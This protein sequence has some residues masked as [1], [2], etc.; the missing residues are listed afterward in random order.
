[1]EDVYIGTFVGGHPALD[2]VNSISDSNKSREKSRIGDWDQFKLWARAANIFPE[3][4]LKQLDTVTRPSNHSSILDGVHQLREVTYRMLSS[5]ASGETPSKEHQAFVEAQIKTAISNGVLGHRDRLHQWTI[6]IDHPDWVIGTLALSI[7]S[8]IRSQ[9][10]RKLREC[11]RCSWF[12]LD[13]GR[14]RGR[15]WCDM[16]KCGNRSK[17]QSFRD[18]QKS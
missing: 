15:K 6:A 16:R 17:S 10:F 14:G 8:L 9:D 11:G 4:Y 18:R 2:F 1:M 5:I 12:F 3:E 13:T 7:E